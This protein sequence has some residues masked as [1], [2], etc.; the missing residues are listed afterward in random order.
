MLVHLYQITRC[1][2]TASV[3][4]QHVSWHAQIMEWTLQQTE[5]ITCPPDH[6]TIQAH[7]L[8]EGLLQFNDTRRN[9]TYW[10]V[11]M[12]TFIGQDKLSLA[13]N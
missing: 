6:Y 12:A 7:A 10:H 11:A 5:L 3:H 8:T 2:T 4:F 9:Y 1:H 13:L